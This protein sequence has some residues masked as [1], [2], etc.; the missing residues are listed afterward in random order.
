MTKP[1]PSGY[2][3]AVTSSNCDEVMGVSWK[4]LRAFCRANGVPVWTVGGRLLV[5]T[6]AVL[7]ALER[8]SA[9]AAPASLADE[10]LRI[11]RELAAEL[12][13]DH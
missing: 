7:V 9:Q 8:I 2:A 5:P 12:R 3:A 1:S 13:S 11:E 4:W 10:V 6:H